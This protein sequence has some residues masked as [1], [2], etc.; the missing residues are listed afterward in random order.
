MGSFF[1]ILLSNIQCS[2][3]WYGNSTEVGVGGLPFERSRG[4]GKD[5]TWYV[6]RWMIGLDEMIS[7]DMSDDVGSAWIFLCVSIWIDVENNGTRTF[8]AILL[9][10]YAL[11]MCISHIHIQ[12][13]DLRLKRK[14]THQIFDVEYD[15]PDVH[16]SRKSFY[17]WVSV[18][19]TQGSVEE[20]DF[21]LLCPF[22]Q[23]ALR[24]HR[25]PRTTQK[26]TEM[27]SVWEC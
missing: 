20:C 10:Q 21:H 25:C 5:A 13:S 24:K 12:I 4:V 15:W 19:P 1:L 26:I 17:F 3:S 23:V 8:H 14:Q 9:Q 16:W 6:Q 22:Y 18:H 7:I 27:V 11:V 2:S